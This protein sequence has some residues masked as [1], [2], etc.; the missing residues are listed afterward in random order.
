MVE[1]IFLLT[2]GFPNHELFGITSQIRR[3]AVSIPT[4]IVEGSGSGFRTI[5][6]YCLRLCL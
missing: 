5:L 1:D 2:V 6:Q 4:N 3:S